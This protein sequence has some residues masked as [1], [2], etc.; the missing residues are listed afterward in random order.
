[1]LPGHMTI[2]CTFV[3]WHSD[4]QLNLEQHPHTPLPCNLILLSASPMTS[5]LIP[6]PTPSVFTS[7]SRVTISNPIPLNLIC[8]GSATN[9]NHSSLVCVIQDVLTW[10]SVLYRDAK[11][12]VHLVLFANA[13]LHEQNSMRLQ[14]F[15]PPHHLMMTSSSSSYS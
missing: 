8:P 1:M 5:L 6:H 15:T 13:H 10:S 14:H 11:K 3:P 4:V 2:L 7:F 12:C 9:S